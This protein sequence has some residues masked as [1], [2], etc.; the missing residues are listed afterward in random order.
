MI[1]WIRFLATSVLML[2][3]LAVC[4][5]GVYG[6]F[7]FD[8]A[9]DRM[10]A[11]AMIDTMGIALCMGGVAISAPDWFSALKCVLVIVFW[12]IS[13]PV[14]S[15][16]LCRLE[17]IT[18]EQRGEYMVV[19]QKTLAQQRAEAEAEIA[20]YSAMDVEA[21]IEAAQDKEEEEQA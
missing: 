7:K 20:A 18:D 16:M 1:E 14:T 12:W 10:H 15:H 8:Y 17:I 5:I 3:G 13:S 19:H 4:C 9:A 21:A 6:I 2:A 11:G